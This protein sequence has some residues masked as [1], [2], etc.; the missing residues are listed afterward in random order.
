MRSMIND[1]LIYMS[2]VNDRLT[3]HYMRLFDMNIMVNR[4]LVNHNMRFN[5]MMHDVLNYNWCTY[6]MVLDV[7]NYRLSDW[8]WVVMLLSHMCRLNHNSW[9]MVNRVNDYV[10]SE[11][12]LNFSRWV[13]S[14]C[15]FFYV[16]HVCVL[17]F[18]SRGSHMHRQLVWWFYSN[19]WL[20]IN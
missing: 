8:F 11:I 3:H 6:L 10:R 16:R 15:M 13:Y 5:I 20:H 18:Y 7:L 1:I 12:L 19:S 9:V 4:R 17:A 2:C 14:N